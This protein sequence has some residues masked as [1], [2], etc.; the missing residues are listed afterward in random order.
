MNSQSIDKN[1]FKL[2]Q[3][4]LALV[5]IVVFLIGFGSYGCGSKVSLSGKDDKL[6]SRTTTEGGYEVEYPD[7]MPSVADGK[8]VWD[9]LNC[10]QCHGETGSGVASQCSLD[11]TDKKLMRKQKPVDEYLLLAFGKCAAY[12]GVSHPSVMNQTTTRQVWDL[13]FY[14]R[15]LAVPALTDAQAMDLDAAFGSNCAV[16]HGKKGYGDGPLSKTLDPVPANFQQYNRFFHRTDDLLWDHIANGIK[17]EGMPNFLNKQD[18]SKNVTF[19]EE[20]IWKLVQYVR[21]FEE[22]TE[23][24]LTLDNNNGSSSDNK[25]G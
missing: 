20:Y 16:C 15:S 5:L 3:V 12:P 22:T 18:K 9:K 7:A 23:K 19:N 2:R 24:T 25:G 17:W 10:A 8:V 14:S 1:S 4:E 6:V 11:L 13:V 21:H